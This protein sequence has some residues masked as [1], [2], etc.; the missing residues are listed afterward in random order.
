M[1]TENAH[2]G[3]AIISILKHYNVDSDKCLEYI[4]MGDITRV[5]DVTL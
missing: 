3:A 4:V 2:W 5:T 1:D